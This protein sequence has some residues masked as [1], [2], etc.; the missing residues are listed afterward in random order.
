[1]AKYILELSEEQ[2]IALKE[3]CEVSA[4][5]GMY[6]LHDICRLL[7]QKTEEEKQSHKE[8]YDRL[9]EMYLQY[10]RN[11]RNYKKPEITNILWDLYQVIR[12]RISWDK[13]PEGNTYHI[14]DFDTPMR[15]ASCDLAKI[16]KCDEG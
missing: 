6:Q 3:A 5:I 11:M 9:W 8:I 15:T 14:V 4:R 2:L 7:P 1:M 10:T 12:H 13:H 16:T